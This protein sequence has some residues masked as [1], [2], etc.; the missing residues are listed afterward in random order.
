MLCYGETEQTL[1]KDL[2]ISE[3]EARKIRTAYF[4]LYSGIYKWH[5]A[6][7]HRI[8]NLEPIFKYVLGGRVR[9]FT[10]QQ[11][12]FKA[13]VLNRRRLGE[14]LRMAHNNMPQGSA[15]DIVKLA[16]LRYSLSKRER[17][18]LANSHICLLVHDEMVVH[19]DAGAADEGLRILRPCMEHA[20]KIN[21]PILVDAVI[22]DNW[23]EGK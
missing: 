14:V 16:A 8:K 18:A 9:R 20:A 17:P 10:S 23:A 7:E 3:D 21:V 1:A 11:E 15:A 13:G 5:M 19:V 12:L 6:N 4:T 22:C 2:D